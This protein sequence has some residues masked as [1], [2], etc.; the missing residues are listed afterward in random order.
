V[1][2]PD[3]VTGPGTG[4]RRQIDAPIRFK[5]GSVPILITV[6]RRKHEDVQDDTWLEQVATKKQ[7]VGAAK[8]IAV[9]SSGFTGPAKTTAATFGVEVRTADEIT[10]EAMRAWLKIDEIVQ[11]VERTELVSFRCGVYGTPTG[12][13]PDVV[14]Q[15]E[16]DAAGSSVFRQVP[17]GRQLCIP[18]LLAVAQEQG[19]KL[20]EGLPHDG[21]RRRHEVHI[22]FP[23]NTVSIRTTEGPT[24]R[25]R[26]SVLWAR[27]IT[28]PTRPRTSS[29]CARRTTSCSMS[30]C[31]PSQTI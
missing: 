14:S 28:A 25:P 10:P 5:V 2:S 18:D 31:S 22:N 13:H 29:V 23:D 8:A 21:T 27:L 6:E 16:A 26:T 17:D 4:S 1:K 11:V 20:H 7:K 19:L 9:S 15:M 24:P 12:L 30:G 3:F